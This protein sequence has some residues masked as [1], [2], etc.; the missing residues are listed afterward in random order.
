MIGAS[1]IK[2]VKMFGISRGTVSKVMIAFEKKKKGKRP[3][4]SI[5]L[6]ESQNWL[7]GP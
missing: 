3:Q 2:A 6:A 5:R 7:R 1:V 4:Q